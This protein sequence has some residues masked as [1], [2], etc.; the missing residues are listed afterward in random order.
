MIFKE[1]ANIYLKAGAD[2]GLLKNGFI[3][4][5]EVSFTDFIYI[6]LKIFKNEGRGGG[7]S[8]PSEPP[9]DPPLKGNKI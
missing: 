6:F 9:L 8:E 7:S 2:Q 5:K 4:I 3:C 1:N